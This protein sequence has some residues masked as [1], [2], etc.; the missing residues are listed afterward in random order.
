MTT[1]LA[2]QAV[3]FYYHTTAIRS[4]GLAGTSVLESIQGVNGDEGLS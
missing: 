2:V 3:P 1:H 4:P